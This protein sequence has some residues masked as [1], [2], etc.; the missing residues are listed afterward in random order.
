L[1][2]ITCFETFLTSESGN[3]ISNTVAEGSAII[4]ENTLENRKYVKQ[5]IKEFYKKRS[6]ISHGGASKDILG[7]DI[8]E[9]KKFVQL[10][11]QAMIKRKNEFKARKN[12]LEWLDDQKLS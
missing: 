3:P 1:A 4:L 7:S 10:F 12:I 2:F 6:S 11:I 8:I 9:L 5:R